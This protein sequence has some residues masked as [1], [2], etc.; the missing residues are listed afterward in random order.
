MFGGVVVRAAW[1]L[2]YLGL[3]LAT[4]TVGSFDDAMASEMQEFVMLACLDD[5]VQTGCDFS[6]AKP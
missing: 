6:A 2:R 1:R 3:P 4:G 5:G